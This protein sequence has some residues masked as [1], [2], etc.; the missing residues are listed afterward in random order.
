M[1]MD[2]VLIINE[3]EIRPCAILEMDHVLIINETEIWPCAILEMDHVLIINETEIRPCAILEMD[4][5]L[6]INE[7]EL[8]PLCHN[9]NGSCEKLREQWFEGFGV[10]DTKLKPDALDMGEMIRESTK[11]LTKTRSFRK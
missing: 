3:T 11:D 8:W 1:V 5:V 10:R 4:H 6:I 2:H 7:K 9:G